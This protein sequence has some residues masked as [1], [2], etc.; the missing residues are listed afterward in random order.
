MENTPISET[1]DENSQFSD[2]SKH[3]PRYYCDFWLICPQEIIQI[4]IDDIHITI[5]TKK[6]LTLGEIGTTKSVV[7][8]TS[9]EKL[10][11]TEKLQSCTGICILSV[12]ANNLEPMGQVSLDLKLGTLQVHHTFVALNICS[13]A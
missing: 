2:L 9:F 7:S 3:Y 11:Y 4:H 12:S 5:N 6:V 10:D 8:K 1:E 13:N